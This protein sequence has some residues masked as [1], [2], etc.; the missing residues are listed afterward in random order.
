M[1]DLHEVIHLHERQAQIDIVDLLFVA[2]IAAIAVM[3]VL[4]Q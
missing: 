4:A 1:R 3:V 2:F